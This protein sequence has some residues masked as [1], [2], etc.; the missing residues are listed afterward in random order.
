MN[1]NLKK[2][3]AFLA[4]ATMVTP[5]VPVY[6]D[7]AEETETKDVVWY[8]NTFDN[9]ISDRVD[10]EN[11]YVNVTYATDANHLSSTVKVNGNTGVST[12]AGAWN[13]N[14]TVLITP[15]TEISEG[16][17]V[18]S[19]DASSRENLTGLGSDLWIGYN[20][21]SSWEGTP[22]TYIA[23]KKDGDGN[24]LG[25]AWGNYGWK[26]DQGILDPDKV[27]HFDY[28]FDYSEKTAKTYMDGE[29]VKTNT[30][31][32]NMKNFSFNLGG[33]FDY[34]D[35]IAMVKIEGEK[36]EMTVEAQS[37]ADYVDVE[38]STPVMHGGEFTVN[39]KTVT[40][41]VWN[42]NTAVRLNLDSTVSDGEKITVS[43]S[44]VKGFFD[45]EIK[46]TSAETTASDETV[47]YY[48]T[49]DNGTK[50]YV[51]FTGKELS[52]NISPST[53]P[54]K[55]SITVD[56]KGN[57]G[58]RYVDEC[59]AKVPTFTIEPKEQIKSGIISISFD[60]KPENKAKFASHSGDYSSFGMN[61]NSNYEGNRI[62]YF[63]PTSDGLYYDPRNTINSWDADP[64]VHILLDETVHSIEYVFNFSTC[65]LYHYLDGELVKTHSYL[66]SFKGKQFAVTF[67]GAFSY[68][69]NLKVKTMSNSSF[70]ASKLEAP[71][72]GENTINVVTSER[73]KADTLSAEK[74]TVKK[75]GATVTPTEVKTA[76]F[77]RKIAITLPETIAEN[78]NYEVSVG[79]VESIS[80]YKMSENNT[81]SANSILKTVRLDGNTVIVTINN[82]GDTAI[83]PT[84]FAATY[85]GTTLK[86]VKAIPGSEVASGSRDAVTFSVSDM[87]DSIKVFAWNGV[88]PVI[89]AEYIY[90]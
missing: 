64:D 54:S 41:A 7:D 13:Q 1:K 55:P 79:D 51:S 89:T 27:Y 2:S 45:T 3:L 49:F 59:W 65:K 75:N 81:V 66:D 31:I 40:D 37:F 6:A 9:G 16:K 53:A 76:D 78:D 88:T 87:S 69:D 48:N 46:N 68:F 90:K 38:F 39:G 11:D 30:N 34:V 77:G 25:V 63:T 44:N 4:A 70:V 80:G 5:L 32:V 85:S 35:N 36:P 47:L 72:A 22:M 52:V 29:L 67:G 60:F 23:L 82:T 10:V 62:A 61:M 56:E 33:M 12:N 14:Q 74:I 71:V 17:Y 83:T 26:A 8:R 15:N 58:I 20:F 50:D 73:I 19:W 28:V 21:T 57:K 86:E 43:A 84:V 42:G 18:V 24:V